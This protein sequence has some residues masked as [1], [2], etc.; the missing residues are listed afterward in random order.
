MRQDRPQ[1][2]MAGSMGQNQKSHG[3]IEV[4][5][6][7]NFLSVG[8]LKTRLSLKVDACLVQGQNE[9]RNS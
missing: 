1:V 4:A 7:V 6:E 5:E 3:K 8:P 2:E 9:C